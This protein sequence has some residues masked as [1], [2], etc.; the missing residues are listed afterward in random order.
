ME[1]FNCVLIKQRVHVVHHITMKMYS[2]MAAFIQ[3]WS[4]LFTSKHY[5]SLHQ[6]LS[7][8]IAHG[9]SELYCILICYSRT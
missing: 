2:P 7:R 4:P 8:N 3:Q 5:F 9:L 6:L 1:K